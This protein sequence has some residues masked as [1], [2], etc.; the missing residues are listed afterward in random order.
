MARPRGSEAARYFASIAGRAEVSTPQGSS[1]RPGGVEVPVDA[2]VEA[3]VEVL[4]RDHRK[5]V[6]ARS[7]RNVSP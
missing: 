6:M 1:R 3:P 4:V 2:A 5:T 7:A